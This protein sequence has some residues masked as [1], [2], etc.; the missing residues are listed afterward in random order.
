MTSET[1]SSARTAAPGFRKLAVDRAMR[2]A[3][4]TA[5]R[6]DLTAEM[7]CPLAASDSVNRV[8]D[9]SIED[10]FDGGAGRR[11]LGPRRGG[12][13]TPRPTHARVAGS[14]AS[15]PNRHALEYD[16]RSR[17]LKIGAD[18]RLGCG[19]SVASD[20]MNP[21]DPR[22]ARGIGRQADPMSDQRRATMR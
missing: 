6:I 22:L 11:P 9:A 1:A 5:T 12:R 10:V 3:A 20:E 2:A 13:L 17:S 15:S 8:V 16:P 21:G 4:A 18:R 14:R 19:R 7:R